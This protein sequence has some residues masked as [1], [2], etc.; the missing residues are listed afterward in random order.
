MST[1]CPAPEMLSRLVDAAFED[2]EPGVEEQ[3]RRHVLQCATCAR[4]QRRLERV[5]RGVRVRDAEDRAGSVGPRKPEC[6]SDSE[7]LS[8]VEPRP[9]PR[10]DQHIEVCDRCLQEANALLRMNAMNDRATASV[11][12]A[13][14][15]RVASRWRDD[16]TSSL[17]E[18]VVQIG[19]DGLEL[20]RRHVVAPLLELEPTGAT[21]AVRSNDQ[22]SREPVRFHLQA[23]AGSIE[24]T[25][26]PDGDAVRLVLSLHDPN[27]A[28]L[29]GQR[30]HL[31][32][33][34]RALFS[35]RTGQDGTIQLPRIE[36]GTYEVSCTA[37]DTTFRLDLRPEG[38]HG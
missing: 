5:A 4:A 12:E 14:A 21:A 27:G 31:R 11:P 37:I 20:V 26:F 33:K 24:A 29:P 3:V 2:F 8:L 13:L 35:A 22:A 25:V 9:L 6:L 36:P 30:V 32:Q 38:A 28:G 18:L 7:M 19:R 10:A 34:G 15:E 1:D 17:T 16:S 23:A